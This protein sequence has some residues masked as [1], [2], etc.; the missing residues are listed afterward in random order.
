MLA[1]D[2]A[3]LRGELQ[4]VAALGVDL[5]HW[6][7]MDGHFVPN[8]TF[9]PTVID[10]ARRDSPA[11]LQFDVHLMVERPEDYVEPLAKCG[12]WQFTFQAEATRFAPRLCRHLREHGLRPSIALNPQTPLG[13]LD[14]LLELVDNVLVM[15]V[16]PGF[17]GQS[18]IDACWAKLEALGERRAKRE[19]EFTIEVDGGV[20]LE[21]VQS[22]AAYGVDIAVAGT[23]FFGA[24]DRAALVRAVGAL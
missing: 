5:V 1:S 11:G 6:D 2:L 12:V 18:F 15:T 17:G 3:D 7:V 24:Q 4:S 10:W 21:N 13:A 20:S 16:D 9:G 19:L 22:L 14:H 23:A 8:L